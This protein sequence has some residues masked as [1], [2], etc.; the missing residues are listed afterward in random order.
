LT[1]W[2]AMFHPKL[3]LSM[4][5]VAH[6]RTRLV[7][8]Q[9]Y[10]PRLEHRVAN[11]L[12]CPGYTM[13]LSRCLLS[14]AGDGFKTRREMKRGLSSARPP[15]SGPTSAMRRPRHSPLALAFSQAAHTGLTCCCCCCCCCMAGLFACLDMSGHS[16]SD[17][18]MAYRVCIHVRFFP[19]C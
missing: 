5:L 12:I 4:F 2:Q 11:R 15:G 17:L 10:L 13:Y 16:P 19:S 6:P 8:L 1:S 14:V 18:A 9:P 7:A 3:T